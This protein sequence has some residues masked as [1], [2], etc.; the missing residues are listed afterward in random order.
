MVRISKR[1]IGIVVQTG[2]NDLSAKATGRSRLPGGRD[3]ESGREGFGFEA[4]PCLPVDRPCAWLGSI[5]PRRTCWFQVTWWYHGQ[6]TPTISGMAKGRRI[7]I[8][9]VEE[10]SEK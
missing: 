7:A 6:A 4:S 5:T 2:N 1:T 8:G 10:L 9:A 3:G